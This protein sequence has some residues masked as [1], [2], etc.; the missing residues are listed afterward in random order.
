VRICHQRYCLL[1]GCMDHL[2]CSNIWLWNKSNLKAVCMYLQ[3]CPCFLES[4]RLHLQSLRVLY[5]AQAEP[6]SRAWEQLK[7]LRSTG[8]V[9][10]VYG[11]FVCGFQLN[12]QFTDPY[13]FTN[14]YFIPIRSPIHSVLNLCILF[15]QYFTQPTVRYS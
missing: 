11:R 5:L 6:G 3:N 2:S 15:R 1:Q 10:R 14:R 9:N 4:L 13:N 8:K 12:L 7:I